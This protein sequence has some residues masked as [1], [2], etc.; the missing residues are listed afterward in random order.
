[1]AV[2]GLTDD[3]AMKVF[4]PWELH[5]TWLFPPSV[6]ELVPPEHLAHFVREV[7][8][9]EID[10]TP[11]MATYTEERGQPPYHPA[12][13]TAL[14]LY[15]YTQGL[16]SSRRIEKACVE[17]LDFM[18]VTGMAKPDHSTIAEFRR[19]HRKALAGLFVEVLQLCREAGLVSLGHVSLDGTKVKANAS[20]HKAMSYG[21]M[22]EVEPKLV[23]EVEEWLRKA[24]Q[25]DDEDDD[26]H[27][28]GRRGGELPDWVAN[29]QRRL[30][31]IR[32]AKKRL[33]DQA[34]AEAKRAKEEIALR[35]KRGDSYSGALGKRALGVP[36]EKTQTNFTD[37]ESRIMKTGDGFVQAYNC[38]LAVDAESHVIVAQRVIARQ[39]DC[40]QLVP[41]LDEI[42]ANVGTPREISADAGYC[43]EANLDA[44]EARG[45]R[46]YVATGR[47]A[48]G[49]ASA[50]SNEA[51]SKRPNAAL[52]R[53]RL[54]RGGFQSRYRLRKKTVEPVI[55]Q[56]KEAR[57]FRRFLTRGLEAVAGEWSLIALA[58]NLL[59]L[60][61]ARLAAASE[62]RVALA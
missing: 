21:R 18:A 43:S 39:N 25:A 3:A 1:L 23:A 47:Q 50:T 31:M 37:P 20:K 5:T 42:E 53:A 13:M 51:W 7:V 48:H 61:A 6:L 10:L 30:E 60:A 41:L 17:R 38:Q 36:E 2:G 57:G 35:R 12:L 59:K 45:I 44:I 52:M 29:R 24:E 56:I 62:P 40:D 8:R 11:I 33:E 49:T 19:R 27:G 58:H 16:Y 54:K 22:K 34:K 9:E 14:L 4:R 46:G 26:E 55:G 15:A 32:E 28:K